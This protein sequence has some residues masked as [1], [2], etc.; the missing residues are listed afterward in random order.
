MSKENSP[1]QD[2]AS[3]SMYLKPDRHCKCS[4]RSQETVHAT[5]VVP[6]RRIHFCRTHP[7]SADFRT[8]AWRRR[9][10][11][12]SVTG[13]CPVISKCN[14]II[15]V[16]FVFFIL[17]RSFR[18]SFDFRHLSFAFF[19]YILDWSH[20]VFNCFLALPS[21]PDSSG[22]GRS[23]KNIFKFQQQSFFSIESSFQLHS[24]LLLSIEF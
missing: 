21:G 18:I 24:P 5:P 19:F 1:P 12:P 9:G 10:G 14:V 13:A 8:P 3:L 15:D 23:K 22:F 17:F 4:S 16:M 11:T 7:H 6:N 2:P 20:I